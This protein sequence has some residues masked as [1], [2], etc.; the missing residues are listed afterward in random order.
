VEREITVNVTD[1]EITITYS[2]DPM[3]LEA[4]G[5]DGSIIVSVPFASNF[6]F[7]STVICS[8]NCVQITEVL[9]I[10]PNKNSWDIIPVNSGNGVITVS[11]TAT[12]GSGDHTK[13]KT[14]T[15]TINVTVN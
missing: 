12:I 13:V 14:K 6:S 7:T 3:V 9:S 1:Y 8:T 5:Q 11:A 10:L 4:G 2:P 15:E